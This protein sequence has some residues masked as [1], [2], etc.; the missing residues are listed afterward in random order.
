PAGRCRAAPR[1]RPRAFPARTRSVG[2][3]ALDRDPPQPGWRDIGS[4]EECALGTRLEDQ[5]AIR[6][7]PGGRRLRF[8]IGLVHPARREASLDDYG[9]FT[10][11]RAN[12]AF[13]EP[14]AVVD[15]VRESLVLGAAVRRPSHRRMRSG[16]T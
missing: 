15:V 11:R 7:D 8:E 5:G 3:P 16:P 10:E 12:V 1:A 9:G 6:I 2:H 14:V 13:M 4:G